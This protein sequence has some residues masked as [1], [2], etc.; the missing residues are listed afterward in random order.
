MSASLI[1]N[2]I[3]TIFQDI[4][5]HASANKDRALDGYANPSRR[6]NSHELFPASLAFLEDFRRK[7]SRSANDDESG[8]RAFRTDRCVFSISPI[9]VNIC[10]VAS[11]SRIDIRGMGIEMLIPMDDDTLCL[12]LSLL[13]GKYFPIYS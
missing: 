12:A 11:P 7:V 1:R 4:A 9:E 10:K 3:Y 5:D 13:L 6:G 2:L 8:R